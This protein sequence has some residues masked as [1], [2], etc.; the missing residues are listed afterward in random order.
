MRPSFHPRLVNGPFDDPGLFIPFLFEKRAILFDLGDIHSL[1]TRDILKIT[2]IFVSHT[3]MDHFAGFDRLLRVMLGREKKLFLY[4]PHGFLG[5]VEGKLAGY[6]WNLVDRY[7]GGFSIV[8]TEVSDNETR[9][10]EYPCHNGFQALSGGHRRPF[11]GTLLA[12]PALAVSGVFLDHRIPC[13]G[14][15]L[16]ERFHVN[17]NKEALA[18]LGLSVGP[19]LRDFKTALYEGR[20]EETA[21]KVPGAGQAPA[22]TFRLG[23][24]AEKISRKTSGQ[25][26]VYLTDL[27]GTD[28]NIEKAVAFAKDADQLFVEAAFLQSEQAAAKEKRH[29]TARD[30]GRLAGLARASRYTLFHHSP[31]YLDRP[32]AFAREAAAAHRES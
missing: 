4:G 26:I 27:A 6:T 8:A 9:S 19:W 5:N 28:E 2:H 32:D 22:M 31:R 21:F 30:A 1:P 16:R 20:P 3:H 7:A 15:C 18:E 12:E 24:L 23:N 14:F 11:S 17:I 25:K 10:R 29:L 13:L